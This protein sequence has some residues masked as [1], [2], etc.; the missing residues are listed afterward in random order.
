MQVKSTIYNVI[1]FVLTIMQNVDNEEIFLFEY[2][3]I[4]SPHL[5][6]VYSFCFLSLMSVYTSV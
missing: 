1:Y 3:Y 6:D 2:D 5:E 4:M